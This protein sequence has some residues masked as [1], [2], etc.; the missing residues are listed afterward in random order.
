MS[1]TPTLQNLGGNSILYI[2]YFIWEYPTT[3][4]IPK[5]PVSRYASIN[6][7]F[8]GGVVAVN[9]AQNEF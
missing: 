9:V 2:G 1:F 7:I 3:V 6:V 8:W 4:L 5:F